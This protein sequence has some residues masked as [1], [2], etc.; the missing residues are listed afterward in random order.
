MRRIFCDCCSREID[1]KELLRF[2]YPSVAKKIVNKEDIKI[3]DINNISTYTSMSIELCPQCMLA[4]SIAALTKLEDIR[5]KKN[6]TRKLQN[7]S[8]IK[9]S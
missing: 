6:E 5:K 8:P 9:I 4:A 2:E 7:S 1:R 3:G